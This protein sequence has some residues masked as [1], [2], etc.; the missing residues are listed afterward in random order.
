V[1]DVNQRL[2]LTRA[3]P[4]TD[5]PVLEVGSRDYGS[6]EDWRAVYSGNEY[7][8]ADLSAGKN[9]D[10]VLDLAAGIG[11]LA[12]GHFALIICCSVLEHVRRPWEMAANL[13]RLLRVGGAAYIAVPWVWRYHPYPDD[14]FRFSW[15]GIAELFPGIS[16]SHRALST[17]VTG[18]FTEISG[19]GAGL[20]NAM[21][22][23]VDT[24]AGQRKYLPYIQVHMLGVKS[25]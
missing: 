7:V 12:E 20:D 16:W 22:K 9:V 18:E 13:T 1:G 24:P 15:R 5:G 6:T 4:S 23:F 14:Y 8:G 3:L 25:G 19:D 17:N 2:F 21:A 11:D 10:R